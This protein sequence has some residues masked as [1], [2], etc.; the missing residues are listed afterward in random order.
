[1]ALDADLAQRADAYHRVF[2]DNADTL[3]V[4]D[5]LVAFA[6]S[7]ADPLV[8]AGIAL[9]VHRCYLLRSLPRRQARKR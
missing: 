6:Q 5:D 8:K 3:A 1:M 4:L 9:A 2:A 7:Q